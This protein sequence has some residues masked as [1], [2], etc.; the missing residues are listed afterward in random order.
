[1]GAEL[2]RKEDFYTALDGGHDVMLCFG[3]NYECNLYWGNTWTL[4]V[5]AWWFW[6]SSG[7]C[8]IVARLN[9]FQKIAL[10]SVSD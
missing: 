3:P 2:N 1:L 6:K 8:E 4:E 5:V 10:F 9:G 7:V